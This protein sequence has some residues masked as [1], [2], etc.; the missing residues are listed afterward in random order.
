M[1]E[2]TADDRLGDRRPIH[3]E[4]IRRQQIV[5]DIIIIPRIERNVISAARIT[6]GTD[7]VNRLIAVE[8]SHLDC[9]DI[10]NFGEGAPKVE[11]ED[12]APTD[13]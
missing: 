5:D 12:V 4:L 2:Q 11:G 6:D 8:G 10:R 13:G 1:T 7:D 3:L 9:N